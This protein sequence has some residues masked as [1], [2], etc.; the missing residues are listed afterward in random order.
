[1][2]N[3]GLNALAQGLAG[4]SS[5]VGQGLDMA[6]KMSAIKSDKERL[7]LQ[8]EAADR[9]KEIQPLKVGLLQKEL[10]VS[11]YGAMQADR[12]WRYLQQLDKVV[13]PELR[14]Q[15]EAAMA[16]AQMRKDVADARQSEL[17]ADATPQQIKDSHA[18]AMAAINAS[19]AEAAH[20]AAL[21]NYTN[22]QTGILKQA[23]E[24][25][26]AGE[27]LDSMNDL[28][29]SPL[30]GSLSS[31]AKKGLNDVANQVRAT[32][33]P[34]YAQDP[35]LT[36][37]QDE[38]GL[39]A[40]LSFSNKQPGIEAQQKTLSALADRAQS[41]AELK[42]IDLLGQSILSPKAAEA[43][44]LGLL[45]ND[46][47]NQI[48]QQVTQ[49]LIQQGSLA[50]LPFFAPDATGKNVVNKSAFQ[51]QQLLDQRGNPVTPDE[52]KSF[53][54]DPAS[55]YEFGAKHGLNTKIN[56]FSYD[57][58]NTPKPVISV[59][60][61]NA[62]GAVNS[63]F[64]PLDLLLGPIT[65]G[66]RSL[67]ESVLPAAAKIGAGDLAT[68]EAGPAA[69]LLEY[70]PSAIPPVRPGQIAGE[71]LPIVGE[72]APISQQ[73]FTQQPMMPQG[74]SPAL[75][76]SY[77]SQ[78]APKLLP[79]GGS[80]ALRPGDPLP[81]P[82]MPSSNPFPMGQPAGGLLRSLMPQGGSTPPLYPPYSMPQMSPY[83]GGFPAQSLVDYLRSLIA[84]GGR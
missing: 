60:D 83:Q 79:Q 67:M 47:K 24:I 42:K 40:F 3:N 81:S 51:Y 7:Q 84:Q 75:G 35:R 68:S 27:Q 66:A 71:S 69:N 23:P 34:I 44:R 78:N 73:P 20:S 48:G 57:G 13:P 53:L 33:K 22:T 10:T 64:N 15:H 28:F 30:Y 18:Q 61:P 16:D 9:E 43:A 65:S 45:P 63:S 52:L 8:Q 1:M 14:A 4:L 31:D 36:K 37:A 6:L 58:K 46:V 41:E 59:N 38:L 70:K 2:P 39:S 12:N 77:V 29:N 80:P 26:A 54:D 32:G 72:P 49:S 50:P 17:Q 21:T 19:S 25:K 11:T 76:P 56:L 55:A 5:G 82:I 62:S 74:G